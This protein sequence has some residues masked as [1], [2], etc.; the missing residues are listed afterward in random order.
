MKSLT[1]KKKSTKKDVNLKKVHA[2]FTKTIDIERVT[3][4]CVKTLLSHEIT[5]TSLFLIKDGFL[6]KC[7]KSDLL[8]LFR[9]QQIQESEFAPSPKQR[10]TI[11]DFNAEARKIESWR[12]K[13]KVKTF[14]DVVIEIRK[15]CTQMIE[16]CKRIDFVFDFY[17]VNSIKSLERQ[18]RAYPY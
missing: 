11:I 7:N 14:G 15:S 5:F 4:Y 3:G 1:K 9:M 8:D 16:H 2:E 13:G 6:K 18:R 17:L 12:E 10:V